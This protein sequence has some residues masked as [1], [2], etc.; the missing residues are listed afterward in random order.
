M[1]LPEVVSADQWRAA[2]TGL[3][4]KEKELTQGK[5]DRR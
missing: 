5:G 2:Q 4:A 1:D 3:R